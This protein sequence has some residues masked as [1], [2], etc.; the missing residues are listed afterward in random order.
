[1][2]AGDTAIWSGVEHAKHPILL[3]SSYATF[4]LM[5]AGLTGGPKRIS[6]NAS[7]LRMVTT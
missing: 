5:K 6:C 1:M 3:I 4:Q 7:M 2:I